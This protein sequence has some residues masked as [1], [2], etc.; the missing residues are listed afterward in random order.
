MLAPRG[1]VCELIH[2]KTL[3]LRLML[4]R[5]AEKKR[6]GYDGQGEAP[7]AIRYLQD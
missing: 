5:E 6:I 1:C 2:P 4:I 3:K 7:L